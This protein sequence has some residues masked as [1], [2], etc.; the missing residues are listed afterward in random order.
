MKEIV[1]ALIG[2]AANVVTAIIAYK[3][4][5]AMKRGD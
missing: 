3:T 4:Y 5:K 1:I 2:T